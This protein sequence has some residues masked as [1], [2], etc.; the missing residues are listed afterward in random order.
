MK[1]VAAIKFRVASLKMKAFASFKI[2]AKQSVLKKNADDSAAEHYVFQLQKRAMRCWRRLHAKTIRRYV[3]ITAV[4]KNWAHNVQLR[5]LKKWRQYK[6]KKRASRAETDSALDIY[7][8]RCL[9]LAFTGFVFAAQ[10]TSDGTTDFSEEEDLLVSNL[11]DNEPSIIQEH[12]LTRDTLA[13]PKRPSFLGAA[14]KIPVQEKTPE[15]EYEELAV[16]FAEL[17]VRLETC[18][19][20]EKP[21][22]LREFQALIDR[23][24]VARSRIVEC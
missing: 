6:D 16:R 2:H 7:N 21:E 4:L 8:Q 13:A 5:Q 23:I 24:A 17:K 14:S 12:K 10:R 9:R 19:P 11:D 20:S 18:D 15:A 1:N 3:M 22:T